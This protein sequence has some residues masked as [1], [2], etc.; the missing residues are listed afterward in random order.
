VRAD[1]A[2]EALSFGDDEMLCLVEN[3][4]TSGRAL[5]VRDG[6]PVKVPEFV[7]K[8]QSK[9]QQFGC[10]LLL[11][12]NE[13]NR[14]VHR[15]YDASTGKDVW[16]KVV[17]ARSVMLHSVDPTLLGRA[18]P[19]GKVHVFEAR[20][21]KEVLKASVDPRHLDQAR[22]IHLLHDRAR[23]YL[24]INGPLLPN[25][26]VQ[27]DAWA[28]VQNMESVAVNGMVYCFDGQTGETQWYNPVPHQWLL[29]EKFEEMPVL[30]FVAGLN[31]ETVP[32]GNVK[33]VINVHSIDRQTG[34]RLVHKDV[35]NSQGL[36]QPFHALTVDPIAHKVE[37]IAPSFKVVHAQP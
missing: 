33:Q 22:E 8:Y 13:G 34:K 9:V 16:K 37:L 6:V 31:R 35:D 12:D 5:R 30:L 29:L 26:G 4:A 24:A 28:F 10:R 23:F 14:T 11:V 15:L 36:Y 27:G 20:T 32:Q 3:N 1:V 7:T 2:A 18:D 21:G 25:T 19:D 17:P